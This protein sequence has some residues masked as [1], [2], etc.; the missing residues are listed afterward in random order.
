MLDYQTLASE[1]NLNKKEIIENLKEESV[2]VYA[3]L[4]KQFEETNVEENKLFQFLFRS[5][6]RLDNA[7]LSED[8]KTH[9]FK[10]LEDNRGN[11]SIKPEKIAQLLSHHL[12]LKGDKS[13]QY[14]FA[15]KLVN[16]LNPSSPIY[17]SE[18]ARVF[19]FS[20]YHLSDK[21]KKIDRFNI[22]QNQINEAYKFIL[23][24]NLL[25][26]T[27]EQF[28][29]KFKKYSITDTKKIDFIFWS[30]GKLL[31]NKKDVSTSQTEI[32]R[33]YIRSKL[34]HAKE[35][36]LLEV[37]LISRSIHKE[38]G[39][40]NRFPTVCDAMRT[41]G[42]FRMEEIQSPPK[43]RGAKLRIRYYLSE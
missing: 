24:E 9:Y 10:L 33:D 35:A 11:L 22:Y 16:M 27:F 5:F 13:Y 40:I 32:T 25:E 37:D 23:Q 19:Q 15:T 36:G 6:Y 41:L 34:L 43:G 31:N 28:R 29:S 21:D 17:D 4:T 12:R 8:F 14:S 7:G 18:V 1:I 3:F 2:A 30:Y 42:I 39:Y 38:L 20:T 26:P